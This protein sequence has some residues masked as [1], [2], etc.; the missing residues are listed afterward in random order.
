NRADPLTRP[1]SDVGALV[2]VG[3]DAPV[4][5]GWGIVER[6]GSRV[7]ASDTRDIVAAET[8]RIRGRHNEFNALVS[9]ALVA[10]AGVDPASVVNAVREFGGLDHRCQTVSIIDGV[11]YINDSKATNIGACLAALDGLGD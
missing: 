7:L 1:I 6:H 8:L 11:T 4:R 10:A 9:L 2:S 3:L 5:N